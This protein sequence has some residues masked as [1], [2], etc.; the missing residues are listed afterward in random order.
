MTASCSRG[1]RGSKPLEPMDALELV[2]EARILFGMAEARSLWSRLGLPKVTARRERGDAMPD[3]FT[4]GKDFDPQRN[5]VV[6]FLQQC[7]RPDEN[8]RLQASVLYEAYCRWAGGAHREPMTQSMFGRL[9]KSVGVSSRRGGHFV[10]YFGIRLAS[11]TP[12]A[13]LRFDVSPR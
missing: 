12:P 3:L 8:C 4:V 11:E 7:C 1:G 5:A 9:V 10:F 2:K 6:D 13:A